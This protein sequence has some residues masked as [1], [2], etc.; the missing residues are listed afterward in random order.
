MSCGH[1]SPGCSEQKPVEP[2]E[3]SGGNICIHMNVIRDPTALSGEESEEESEKEGEAED[4]IEEVVTIY[5]TKKAVSASSAKSRKSSK[6]GKSKKSG[7]SRKS[8]RR[9]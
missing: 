3:P 5:V 9:S 1:K 7:K 2:A 4:E 8:S 6:P